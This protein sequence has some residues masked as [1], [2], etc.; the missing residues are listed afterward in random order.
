[1]FG[2]RA[3][4]MQEFSQ[5]KIEGMQIEVLKNLRD[6][7]IDFS[8][9]ELTAIMGVN[10]CGKS[11]V[12]HALS[13][14]Y[15]P[16]QNDDRI[17]YKFS[18]WFTPNTDA[19]WSGSKFTMIH[20]YRQ[21]QRIYEHVQQNYTKQSDRWAPRYAKRPQRY[22]A[23]LG[24][25]TCVPKIESEKRDTFIG[26]TTIHKEGPISETVKNKA[27]YIMNRDYSSYNVHRTL[28]S[29]YIGVEFRGV[30][31][32][33]LS[34]GAGEQRLFMILQEVFSAPKYSLLLIDEIDLLLHPDALKKLMIVMKERAMD[35]N[36]QIVFSTHSPVIADME[37]TVNIRYLWQTDNRTFCL[38]EMKPD[39]TFRLTGVQERPL[40]IYVEDDFAQAIVSQ[41]CANL[42]M[43]RYVSIN[44]YG[45][46]INCF[47][48]E[49]GLLL[50]DQDIENKLFVLDGDEYREIEEKEERI[51]QV[52]TGTTEQNSR[53]RDDALNH[54]VDLDLPNG[55][56]PEEFIWQL[57]CG[58][59][60]YETDEIWQAA[61]DINKFDNK[62][63]YIEDIIQRVG[64]EKS[65]MLYR[66]V[67]MISQTD[68]WKS[69]TKDINDWLAAKALLVKE[70][71]G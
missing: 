56:A 41:V 49:C 4:P 46:A 2:V 36:L 44:K 48:V 65:V 16:M 18:K 19:L 10:G 11:T 59:E 23:F 71:S 40:E 6:V 62:H 14:C 70:V 27:G 64:M 42:G 26:Y 58:L 9:S 68:E 7:Y 3:L 47:T 15:K 13:C 67:N 8:G 31:Y 37:G 22:V 28:K 1:M 24:I 5:Q 38:S 35:K 61:K 30:A 45:A 21:G 63:D 29:E 52:L 25:E 53:M 43:S 39:T 33:A 55:L 51:N 17:N 34:M 54:I 12:L 50:M 69:Y 57:I 60:N 32:S 66:I 20:S